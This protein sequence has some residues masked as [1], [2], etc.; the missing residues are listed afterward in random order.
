MTHMTPPDKRAERSMRL[1]DV[2]PKDV[3]DVLKDY[4][5]TERNMLW[6][7]ENVNVVPPNTLVNKAKT[8]A[9]E[10]MLARRV[11]FPSSGVY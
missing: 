6:L 4:P 2:L 3:R 11:Y 1:Y 7:Y 10:V 8:M 9:K 5:I